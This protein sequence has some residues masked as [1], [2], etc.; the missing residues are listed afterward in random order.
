ML[1]SDDLIESG[2]SLEFSLASDIIELVIFTTDEVFMQTLRDAVGGSRRLWH[3]PSA[4]KVSDM[5]LAGQVGILV[6]DVQALTENVGTFIAMIKRQFPNLV[7]VVAGERNAES[8]LAALISSGTVYRFIHKPMSPGRAKL[9]AEAA[10]RK[11]EETRRRLPVATGR[12]KGTAF[13]LPALA[14]GAAAAAVALAVLA[15]WGALHQ[16]L[17]SGAPQT[18]GNAPSQSNPPPVVA[19]NPQ[20]QPNAAESFDRPAAATV[21]DS[22]DKSKLSAAKTKIKEAPQPVVASTPAAVAAGPA[23]VAAAAGASGANLAARDERVARALGMVD[24]RIKDDRLIEPV[25]DNARYY[26][27][28]AMALDPKGNATLGAKQTLAIALLSD[29]REAIERRDLPYASRLIDAA[30]G[31]AAPTNVDNARQLLR[32]AQ[33]RVNQAPPPS[34]EPAATPPAPAPAAALQAPVLQQAPTPP[35]AT[36][37]SSSARTSEPP[38]AGSEIIAAKDLTL[39]KSVR[40]QYPPRAEQLRTEGW[41]E[42]DFTVATTGEVKDIS[43]HAANPAGL[44]DKSASSALAQ[45]RYLPVVRDSTPVEQ[46]S[47]IRI[48]FTLPG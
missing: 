7:L 31:V 5:L 42:L 15:A 45:W 39:V 11:Y 8:G 38:A 1:A 48:R 29:A 37:Q 35:P 18:A 26:M 33:D 41:V 14:T 28:E 23:A 34:A 9:F 17:G 10:C 25:N 32:A 36:A 30:T 46:R 22:K 20:S 3:V 19:G 12:K 4:D 27:Q 40:P 24:T 47:R 21:L 13:K 6:L 2:S 16:R 43:V 44:F